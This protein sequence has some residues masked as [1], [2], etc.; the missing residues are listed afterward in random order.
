MRLALTIAIIAFLALVIF[1]VASEII[2]GLSLL[3]G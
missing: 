3:K 2:I 1:G